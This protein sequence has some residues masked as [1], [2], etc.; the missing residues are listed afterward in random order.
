MLFDSA[1]LR[2]TSQHDCEGI[3]SAS[4]DALHWLAE[5]VSCDDI[6]VPQ[7]IP[8]RFLLTF[9]IR[10]PPVLPLYLSHSS[11]TNKDYFQTFLHG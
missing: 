8:A 11:S 7:P 2:C 4:G 5:L 3:F 6:N 10:P 1:K 9:C